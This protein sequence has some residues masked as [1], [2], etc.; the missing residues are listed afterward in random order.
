MQA[1][2]RVLTTGPE[3]GKASVALAVEPHWIGRSI[4][5]ENGRS[6]DLREAIVEAQREVLRLVTIPNTA[7]RSLRVHWETEDADGRWHWN[8]QIAIT[9]GTDSIICVAEAQYAD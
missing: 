2:E 3:T 9:D 5:G 1:R 8:P 4:T 6:H 7:F